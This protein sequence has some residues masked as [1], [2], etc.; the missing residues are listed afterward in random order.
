M[1]ATRTGLRSVTRLYD[2]QFN[3]IQSSFVS[4]KTTQLPKRLTTQFCFKLFV[5]FLGSKSDICQILN[6]NAFTAFFYRF[7]NRLCNS[8]INYSSRCSFFAT[9]PFQ[10]LFSVACAFALNRTTNLLFLLLISI[11]PIG[12]MFHSIG[13]YDYIG[14]TKI[15][16]DETFNIFN[17]L[18]RNVNGLKKIELAFF[19][20]QISLASPLI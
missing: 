20:N 13:C 15:Y 7:Y 3:S 11:N 5:A 14:K 16:S 2:N 9:K 17:I 8:M 12:R 4:E 6:G 18:F 19:V 1:L 10:Q